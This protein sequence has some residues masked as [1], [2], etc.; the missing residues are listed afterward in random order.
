MQWYRVMA[1]TAMALAG[2]IVLAGTALAAAPTARL[3]GP[4]RAV[5]GQAVTLDASESTGDGLRFVW[6]FGDGTFEMGGAKVSHTFASAGTFTVTVDVVNADGQDA[7]ASLT[8]TVGENMQ[9]EPTGFEAGG[10]VVEPP[11]PQIVE[12]PLVMP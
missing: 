1:L 7:F 10:P 3:S 11:L 12:P 5:A 2:A 8:I 9:M 4:S 6:N